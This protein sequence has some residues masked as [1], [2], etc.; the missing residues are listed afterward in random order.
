MAAKAGKPTG[1]VFQAEVSQILQMLCGAMKQNSPTLMRELR[2]MLVKYFRL[3]NVAEFCMTLFTPIAVGIGMH[4]CNCSDPSHIEL[5]TKE[6]DYIHTL[7][8]DSGLIPVVLETCKHNSSSVV[9]ESAM[10]ILNELARTESNLPAV[11]VPAVRDLVIKAM[12][13]KKPDSLVFLNQGMLLWRKMVG[14]I[15]KEPTLEAVQAFVDA[16]IMQTCYD[17]MNYNGA[18]DTDVVCCSIVVLNHMAKIAS[19]RPSLI[20]AGCHEW[21]M[22]Q[23]SRHI[24]SD[25]VASHSGEVVGQLLHVKRGNNPR[26]KYPLAPTVMEYLM[27]RD[28]LQTLLAAMNFHLENEGT[29]GII[30]VTFQSL[31]TD[32]ENYP[33]LEE[34]RITDCVARHT[35]RSKGHYNDHVMA[36][37]LQRTAADAASAYHTKRIA[38]QPPELLSDDDLEAM[39]VAYISSKK[40]IETPVLGRRFLDDN[41]ARVIYLP[42]IGE[43]PL[44]AFCSSA[45]K[46]LS[47]VNVMA[48]KSPSAL[49]REL[50]CRPQLLVCTHRTALAKPSTKAHKLHMCV[51]REMVRLRVSVRAYMFLDEDSVAADEDAARSM[52]TQLAS[53]LGTHYL[54]KQSE[55]TQ[56][57]M[58][59]DAD[60]LQCLPAGRYFEEVWWG[61][62]ISNN[63]E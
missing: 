47:V 32:P 11:C 57:E 6:H 7:L 13:R 22:E 59:Q 56:Q 1:E 31:L 2:E 52:Y 8:K 43:K 46:S 62:C 23:M 29:P 27:R 28:N 25:D 55:E 19:M 34:M 16:S 39:R 5:Y 24:Q 51:W 53:T 33:L 18:V 58:I 17:A 12:Q 48:A 61:I 26:E 49:K 15:G 9:E 21:V 20:A 3:P 45:E 41:S 60:T 30:M 38:E 40:G 14:H 4:V 42:D 50:A 54:E 36:R 35:E 37:V 10:T 44:E 63:I